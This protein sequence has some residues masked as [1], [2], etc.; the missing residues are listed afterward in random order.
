MPFS[1]KSII[2][3][4]AVSWEHLSIFAHCDDVSL[5]SK[6]SSKRLI[7]RRWRSLNDWPACFFQ[8]S[9]FT[10]MVF[11]VFSEFL[12]ECLKHFKYHSTQG[13]MS[14]EPFLQFSSTV[15]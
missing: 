4:K 14:S 10:N 13:V 9:A 11:R 1:N 12:I 7:I 6:P 8:N 5:P 2:S 3:R 15:S